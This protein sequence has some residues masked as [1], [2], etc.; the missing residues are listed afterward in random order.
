MKNAHQRTYARLYMKGYA[1]GVRSCVIAALGGKC[2]RCGAKNPACLQIDHV[3]GGGTRK[4]LALQVY[5]RR[6]RGPHPARQTY[7]KKV[8]REALAGSKKYQ[9]LCANRNWIKRDKQ[10]EHA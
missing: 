8:I 7:Y 1:A 5:G 6:S 4:E 3:R 10:G 9:L 2:K